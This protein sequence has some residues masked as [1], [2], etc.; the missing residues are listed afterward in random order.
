MKRMFLAVVFAMVSC[1]GFM[2]SSVAEAADSDLGFVNLAV[3]FNAYP[4][5]EQAQ[6]T[7]QDEQ[8]KLQDEFNTKAASMNDEDKAKLQQELNQKLAQKK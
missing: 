8:T 1:V 6:K 5:M 4:G 3:V 2:G 7:L